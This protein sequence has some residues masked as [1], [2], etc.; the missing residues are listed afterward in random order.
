MGEMPWVNS[1]DVLVGGGAG[2][3]KRSPMAFSIN[4]VNYA[5]KSKI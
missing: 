1:D 4:F 3:I 2:G 5:K